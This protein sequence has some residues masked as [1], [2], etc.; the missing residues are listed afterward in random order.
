MKRNRGFSLVEIVIVV[1]I[2]VILV[3]LVS[4]VFARAK[5]AA[6]E[7]NSKGRLRQ[8]FVTVALY[9]EEWDTGIRQGL[10]SEMGYP[11]FA[12]YVQNWMQMSKELYRSPCAGMHSY[13]AYDN[14]LW[15]P[16]DEPAWK[17]LVEKFGNSMPLLQDR[18]CNSAELNLDAPFSAKT[19]VAVN[20]DGA[21][22][23]RR[24]VG[25]WDRPEWWGA[26]PQS[27]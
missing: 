5:T 7:T 2:I 16:D 19:G 12:G 11:T 27:N 18:A 15:A 3:A 21:I 4:P 9:R 6:K 13:R 25:N 23:T 22:F 20:I 17:A 14:Y 10:A 26:V 1:S 8:I 24:S